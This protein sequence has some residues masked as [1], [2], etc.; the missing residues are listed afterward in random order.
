M[1]GQSHNRSVDEHWVENGQNRAIPALI[2]RF[3]RDNA[4]IECGGIWV[5]SE[6]RSERTGTKAGDSFT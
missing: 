6:F 3:L 4:D 2:S 5:D 1:H